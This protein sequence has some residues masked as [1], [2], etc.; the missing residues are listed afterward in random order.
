MFSSAETE[1]SGLRVLRPR[2][3]Q[4]QRGNFVKTFQAELFN[5]LGLSFEPKEEFYSTSSAGVLRG[6]HFQI[7]PQDHVKVVY[8]LSGRVLD[9]VVDLRKS[10]PTFGRSHA[11]ELSAQNREILFVPAGFAHGFLALAD[12]TIMF[13]QTSTV[14]SPAHDAGIAWNSI[15]F[16]WPV[17]Q[18]ILSDRDKQFPA[19]RDFNSPF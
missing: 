8:C 12:N 15:D 14:H 19:L 4:D 2:V 13:Y 16:K 6:L 1:L 18:P 11:R 3:F 9:V 17:E 7:P 5:N 10:S